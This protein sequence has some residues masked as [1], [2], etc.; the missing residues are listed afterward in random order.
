VNL[1]DAAVPPADETPSGFAFAETS[2]SERTGDELIGATLYEFEPGNQL[3]PYH[4]HTG[5]E[6]WLIV[7]AGT[8]TLRT[9]EG[10]RELRAADVV[11]FPSGEAG[12]HTLYNRTDASA[13][14]VIFST[15]RRGSTV[16]PD[17]GK[18]AAAGRV[19]RLA[20]AVDY[21]DGE[22]SGA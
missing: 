12:A 4:F 22:E 18:V 1:R 15:L 3:W 20:D 21:W 11:G 8:P 7:V 10:E 17:S 16:Y 2:A 13:R 19:F 6:E 9:P 5:N 14:V